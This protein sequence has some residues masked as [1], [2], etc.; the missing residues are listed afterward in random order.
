MRTVQPITPKDVVIIKQNEI[1]DGIIKTFNELIIKHFN[2]VSST[3]D[4]NQVVE[5][6]C[7]KMPEVSKDTM[8]TKHWFDIEDLYNKNGWIVKFE[9]PAHNETFVSY[10]TFTKSK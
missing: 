6:A 1:P 2:G 4:L 9:S 8:F 5:L 7:N 10:F 3:F